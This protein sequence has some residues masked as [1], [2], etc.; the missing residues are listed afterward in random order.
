MYG[1]RRKGRG[2]EGRKGRGRMDKREKRGW[3]KIV[4]GKRVIIREE[5]DV[6]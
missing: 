6:R 3:F 4:K 2:E 1:N 5:K